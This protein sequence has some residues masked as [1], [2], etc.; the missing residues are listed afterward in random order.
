MYG[1]GGLCCQSVKP[2]VLQGR[3]QGTRKGILPQGWGKIPNNSTLRG[4]VWA[5]FAAQV[6]EEGQIVSRLSGLSRFS[7]RYERLYFS[8]R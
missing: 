2:P 7:P 5:L 8:I 6:T 3:A 4:A 1:R